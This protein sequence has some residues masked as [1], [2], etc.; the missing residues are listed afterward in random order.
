MAFSHPIHH[1]EKKKKKLKPWQKR[2]ELLYLHLASYATLREK[3]DTLP[4]IVAQDQ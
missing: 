3:I 1:A 2:I 4:R